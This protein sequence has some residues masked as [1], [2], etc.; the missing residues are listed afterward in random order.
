MKFIELTLLPNTLCFEN[1]K[2]F[3]EKDKN[4]GTNCFSGKMFVITKLK[5]MLFI[6]NNPQ[7]QSF[8]VAKFMSKVCLLNKKFGNMRNV[9]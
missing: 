2:D 6:P 1:K 9:H 7:F 4:Q 5:K 8:Y 3:L